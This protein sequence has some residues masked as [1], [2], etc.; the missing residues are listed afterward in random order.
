[1]GYVIEPGRTPVLGVAGSDDLFPVRRIYTIGRNYADHA[2]ETG[3]GGDGE[4]V[5]GVSLKPSDSVLAGGGD[6]PYPPGTEHLDPEVEMVVAIGTGGA[7]IDRARAL[8]YV[9]GYG[10]GF[11][12][13]R[14]DVMRECL[15]NEHSWDLCKSFDGASPCSALRPASEIGHPT[16]GAIW[17]EV[18]GERRQTGDLGDL[19]WDVPEIV[20][21]LSALS[22]VEPGDLI[23]TGTPKG[24][25]A[26]ARGNRVHG[27]VDGIGDVTV[28]IV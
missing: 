27:H 9:Y 26:V 1:L 15:R 16:S 10:V 25:A 6:L 28:T 12:M 21:R 2:A 7:D 4:A 8:D 5:P 13:I 19:I 14:R 20:A 3:L 22:R 11:D 24:P 17:L 18:D 23:F